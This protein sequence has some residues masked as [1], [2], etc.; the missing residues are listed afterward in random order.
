MKRSISPTFPTKTGPLALGALALLATL[1]TPASA[2]TTEDLK[3]LADGVQ[4]GNF[5]R[6]VAIS[7]DTALIG[8]RD[9]DNGLYAG[10]AYVFDLTTGQQVAKLLAEDGEEFDHFG[11]AV[12]ISG[13]TALIG[14]ERDDDNGFQAGAAYVFDVTT[15]LQTAKLLASDGVAIDTFGDSVAI[16][17][18]TALIGAPFNDD[19][20]TSAGAAYVFDLTTGQQTAKLLA[21]DGEEND[22]FGRSVAISGDTAL[23]GAY[24]DGDNGLEAGAAYVFDV[25][26][27]Q[28]VAKLLASDGTASDNFGNSVAISGHTAVIGAP[29]DDDLGSN[30]GAAYVFDLTTGQQIA[31]LLAEDG[32]GGDYFG[33]SVAISGDTVLIG[34][35][36]DSDSAVKAGA[37]YVFDLTTGQQ[38]AKL[39]ASDGEFYDEFGDSVAISGDTA[40]I[41]AYDDDDTA[42]SAGAAYVYFLGP[43]CGVTYCG[44]D[45]NP[46]NA[47]T[48]SIDTCVLD[49]ASIQLTLAGGPAGEAAYLLVGDGNATVSA[50]PGADGDLCIVGGAS[51]ARYISAVGGIDAGGSYSTDIKAHSTGTPGS[52]NDVAFTVGST[53]NFQYWH[54]RPSANSSFSQAIAVTFE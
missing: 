25:T 3:L 32:E 54:R 16:S 35:R 15:G 38:V 48:I 18:D 53:W 47:A 46:N 36:G 5:G 30:S 40:L 23:I 22:R 27:G 37:A 1:A 34:A 11:D 45:Q 12:A 44:A 8:A 9:D 41:G 33:K 10:A 21:S 14:A 51:L 20:G 50:P 26:T 7:G 52:P 4:S 13:D 31:K 17:G 43:D 39:L 19:K 24:L 28:Q 29:R 6:S 42:P 2:Q 49:S